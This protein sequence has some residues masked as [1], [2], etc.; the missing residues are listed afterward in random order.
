MTFQAT[1][2]EG[3]ASNSPT[4]TINISAANDSAVV[5][6][7]AG[8]TA[9]TEGAAAVV[10]DNGLTVSDPD[11]TNL[12]GATVT[13]SGGLDSGDSLEYVDQPGITGAGSGT[14]TVTL[15]GTATVADYQAALRTVKFVTTND[16]PTVTKTVEFK[17]NDG[18]GLGNGA[19]KTITVTRVND[20]PTIN[21]AGTT[22]SY[23][24]GDGAVPVDG[25]LT[26]TDPDSTQIQGATVQITGNHVQS[27]DDLAFADTADI[28]GA[29]DDA[30]GKLTLSG[31]DSVADYQTALASVT[32]E[33][34]SSTPTV[35]T[36]TVSFQA[37]DAEGDASNTATR[38]I[39]VG[40]VNDAPV[41]TTTAGNT[42]YSEGD[43][44]TV[45]DNGVTVTDVDDTDLEDATVRISSGFQSGDQLNFTDTA[46][47]TG[48]YTPGT[49]VL[50]L[51]GTATVAQYQAALRTIEFETTN[52]NPSASKTVEFKVNDGDVDSNA[53]TRGIAITA[54]NS[55]P[56]LDAGGTLA[57]TENDPAT[58]VASGLTL[59]EP[60]GNPISGASASVTSGFESGE[61]T[62]AWTDNDLGDAITLDASNSDN[63]T[64]T[65][66]G[67]DSAANYQAAL[68][69]ITYVNSS[70]SPSTTSREVTFSA[71]DD[72]SPGETATSVR[73]ITVASVD[74]DPVAVDDSATV[75]E[76]AAATSIDVLANDTDLDAGPKTIA[77][78]SDPTNGTVVLTGGSPGAHTGLTYEPDPDY[79]NDPPGTSPDTF[80]YTLNSGS[81]ATVSITVTCVNDPPV[82]DDETFNGNDSAHGNTTMVVNDP[83]DG[84]PNPSRPKT[85]ISGD[86]LAG[87]TDVDGPGPLTVTPGTFATNDGG[88][89]TIE[90]DGD[91]TF[92]P[93]A[94]TSC[95]DNSD[96]FDY[97][98]KDS[99]SPEETDTGRVTI[100]IAGCVW[101]VNN[102]AAGN[103]GTSAAPFDTLAQAESASGSNHTVF[104][105][106]GDNTSTGYDT[107]YA[108][109]SGE[110]LIGEH[111][112][113]VVD[114]DQGGGLTA[115]TLHPANPGAHPT[116]TA[117]DEDVIA[118][119]DGNEV[120]GFNVDPEGTGGGI[121]GAAGDTGGGTIDD[122]NV[123]DAGTFGVQPGV[124]LDGTAGTF[125]FSNLTV[126]TDGATGIRLNSAGTA[127]FAS[128]GTISLTSANAPAIDATGTDMGTSTF[129]DITVTGSDDG[130]VVMTN[131]TGTTTF[132]N[133]IGTDLA[134]T[135]GLDAVTPV[136]SF[137]LNSAGTAS[138]PAGG[139]AN[140]TATGVPAID[141]TGTPGGDFA[142]DDVDSTN[143]GSDGINLAGL[144][145]GSFSADAN[146]TI[147]G[148]AG[149][150]FDL[151]G[152]SGAVTFPGTFSNGSGQT[153]EITGRTGGAV[154]FSGPVADTSDQGGGISLSTN[155]GGSTTFS[156]ASKTINTT[157]SGSPAQ[158]NAI[159]MLAS[160]G[161]TLDLT[162]GGL[163]IDSTGRGLQADTSGTLSVTGAGNSIN[164]ISGIALDVSNTDIGASDLTF[165]RID[166]GNATAAAD[167]ANGIVLNTTGSA[168]ELTVTSSA[169][170][171]P[172]TSGDTTGCTGGTIQ[173]TVG[174]DNSSATPIGTGIVLNNTRAPSFTRMHIHDNSNYGIRGTAVTGLTV[175]DSVINGTNGTNNL[176][177]FE[178]S[179]AKFTDLFGTVSVADTD[180]S[181]G[182]NGNLLVDNNG[183]GALDA[184]VDQ[185]DFGA[186]SATAVDDSVR[187]NG[188]ANTATTMDVV[189]TGATFTSAAGDIF[190]WVADGT[191]GGDLVFTSNTVSNNHP[192]IVNGGGGVTLTGGARAAATLN[193]SDNSFRDS[194]TSALTINKSRDATAGAGSL[195]GTVDNNDIG[196]IADANSGSL[197]GA[198]IEATHFGESNYNLTVTNNA[199]HQYNSFGLSFISGGGIAE[200]GAFNLNISGN[201]ISNPGTNPSVTLLQGIGVNSGVAAGDA[202]QTC[203]NFGAN[204]ITGSSD[205][206]NKDFRLRARQNTTVR[207]PGYAGAA[208][209]PGA[210]TDVPTFVSGKVGGGAQGTA[211]TAD[212]GQFIGTGTTCP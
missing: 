6:T 211:L 15:S 64:I 36:R 76:D 109:N 172:C 185:V 104:V 5:A 186:V 93:A 18:D 198:G 46:E 38:D 201:T 139:T 94:S 49:G 150:S 21:T 180:I 148:A 56:D 79:C 4:R 23:E 205:V 13:I 66:T 210:D 55:P 127:S 53:A 92:E 116:L 191:G 96:F 50:A 135:T 90:A 208:T 182:K 67:T 10:V 85:T 69:A 43:P 45:I 140:V 207:L 99:G 176:S 112:G 144:G 188:V 1:D 71:T 157:T 190:Q 154:S 158:N 119:D 194:H 167:P 125:S 105:F 206:A 19:S 29:Y 114:P 142:F 33:N 117:T 152:G 16:N 124:E 163:D 39:S 98:V 68:R 106:D 197:D 30:T 26:L 160:D 204:S 122:V 173:N 137:R 82:A 162:G 89:V 161:H 171:N 147:G 102:S 166:A 153:A 111:E 34:S 40:P 44:G 156:N 136:P 138:V 7:S 175:A 118:L 129:D 47:I 42:A 28:T 212:S 80:T 41:V 146:S 131:T 60:E 177:P 168:G 128:A 63:Q 73:T 143:S 77:S 123:V 3:D 108:M 57:Y 70:E 100:A 202:F 187:F 120:R 37:T 170:V 62:L 25:T 133:G 189:V 65:L 184:T 61:D 87:D 113:L 115:D 193:V 164:S 183:S 22:L 74:D 11:D 83:S 95:T 8:S 192:A 9:Y 32:Y 14:S 84:A 78:A 107:G 132:G 130:G 199:I 103:S 195:T 52:G 159:T 151:D 165:Q 86:I 35:S 110:R 196:V 48:T 88:S 179:S 2:A 200:T 24:E 121:A 17:A 209:S 27:E 12:E 169:T 141:I 203:V 134:L 31:T 174:A 51:T 149:I 126:S 20:G 81:T 75:L 181:G 59:T 54:A 58:A 101:Y 72:Q 178:D 91:F 155:S 97:T 145:S